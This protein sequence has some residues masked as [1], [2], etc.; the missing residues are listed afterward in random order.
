ML[1]MQ[2]YQRRALNGEYDRQLE[3]GKGG[4]L[5]VVRISKPT[6]SMQFGR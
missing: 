2:Q 5:W 1:H 6:S 4:G 3:F